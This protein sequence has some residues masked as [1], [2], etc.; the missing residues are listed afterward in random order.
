MDYCCKLDTTS[1]HEK[2]KGKREGRKRAYKLA[3]FNAPAKHSPG[4]V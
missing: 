2:G 1:G 4:S 3:K